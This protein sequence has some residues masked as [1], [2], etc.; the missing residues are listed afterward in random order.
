MCK[1]FHNKRYKNT[2]F[3][4]SS[5]FKLNYIFKVSIRYLLEKHFSKQNP[6]TQVLKRNFSNDKNLNYLFSKFCIQKT[7]KDKRIFFIKSFALQFFKLSFPIH[8]S[9]TRNWD[10]WSSRNLNFSSSSFAVVCRVWLLVDSIS[11]QE[12]EWSTD[13]LVYSNYSTM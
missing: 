2:S 6:L 7:W 3:L 11:L 12:H 13:T 1:Q 9:K 10:A 4:I 5:Q 8:S